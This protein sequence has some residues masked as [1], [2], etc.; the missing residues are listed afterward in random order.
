MFESCHPGSFIF[1]DSKRQDLLSPR[2]VK[3]S[4]R[5]SGWGQAFRKINR[6]V[7]SSCKWITARSDGLM[8][9]W[10]GNSLH[11]CLQTFFFLF[12]LE[13]QRAGVLSSSTKDAFANCPRSIPRLRP[14]TYKDVKIANPLP[15]LSSRIPLSQGPWSL[16]IWNSHSICSTGDTENLMHVWRVYSPPFQHGKRVRHWR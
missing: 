3:P 12:L 1:R 13:N 7:N 15:T 4:R 14:Q 16:Q 9:Q 5:S 8:R 10:T 11:F 2:E 6:T